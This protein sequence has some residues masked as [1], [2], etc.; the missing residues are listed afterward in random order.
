MENLKSSAFPRLLISDYAE[1]SYTDPANGGFTKLE[2]ASLL[3]M[4]G[5][6]DSADWDMA[7]NDKADD[8]A[9]RTAKTAVLMAKAV[10]EEANK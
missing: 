2:Y 9:S 5:L 10:I 4:Q 7:K 8:L 3:M 1:A 6:M